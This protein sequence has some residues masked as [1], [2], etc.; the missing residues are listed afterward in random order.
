MTLTL[1]SANKKRKFRW[2]HH[3]SIIDDIVFYWVF[4]MSS[5]VFQFSGTKVKCDL[6]AKAVKVILSLLIQLKRQIQ[7]VMWRHVHGVNTEHS[8]VSLTKYEM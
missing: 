8:I 2:R 7:Q 1:V 4:V 6:H 5:I 3:G